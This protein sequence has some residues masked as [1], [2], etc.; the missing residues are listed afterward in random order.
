MEYF[1]ANRTC[2]APPLAWRTGHQEEQTAVTPF[3]TKLSRRPEHTF[4]YV[5]LC[6]ALPL[7]PGGI[8]L[9]AERHREDAAVIYLGFS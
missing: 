4:T 9:D 5:L 8:G 2:P 6:A 1:T 7:P 3:L